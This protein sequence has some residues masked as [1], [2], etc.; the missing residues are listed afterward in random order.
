M[1]LHRWLATLKNFRDRPA[2]FGRDG[3]LR[4]SDLAAALDQRPRAESTVIAR[5]QAAE[6]AVATLQAWRDGQPLLPL[7]KSDS[8]TRAPANAR[9]FAHL[10]RVPDDDGA[11]RFIGFR[12]EQIAADADRIVA[13]MDL[14]PSTPNLAAISLAHSYG[15]SSIL[16]PLLLHGIPIQTVDVPF[17]AAVRAAM[18][19]HD[20]MVVPAVPS[21][22][23]A[24]HRSGILSSAPIRLA[25]SAGAPLHRD[26][27]L[28]VWNSDGL[29]LH[30]FYGASECGGI[31]YDDRPT[32]RATEGSLG[33]PLPGV[34]V[35]VAPGGTFAVRSPSVAEAYLG[36]TTD[37]ALADGRFV[38]P[39]RGRIEQGELVFDS[40]AGEHINVAGRKLGPA[41]IEAAL[42]ATGLADLV[43]VF[44]VPSSDAERVDEIAVLLPPGCDFEKLREAAGAT[45]AGWEL[46]RHWLTAADESLWTRSRRDLRRH[47]GG[48]D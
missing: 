13:T 21:M 45:L 33:F 26:L 16:L 34:D 43:R 17:P 41:R 39:D 24:W 2:I 5:G 32:P 20:R 42:R 25:L 14:E 35:D 11:G 23:R 37:A 18:S 47:F 46:P 22:W 28:A 10:K 48:A 3:F 44:G 31:S 1:L 30:N 38:T 40:R 6:L 29:K 19:A 12:A 7:E 36:G 15:Y 27:E 4:F 8:A 9:G